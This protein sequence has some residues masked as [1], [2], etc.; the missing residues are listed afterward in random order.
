MK[1]KKYIPRL[2]AIAGFSLA[3]NPANAALLAHYTFDVDNS[4]STPDSVGSNSA[5]LGNRVEINTTI[6]GRIGSGALEMLGSGSTSGPGDGATTSN[7]F[8]W[9][10]DARTV[11]FWWRAD[12]PN[13]DVEGTFVSFGDESAN[14][15]RFDIKEQAA[16]STE[17]RVEVQG[18]GQNTN[19]GIDD[20]NWHFIAV[21]VPN[22]ATFADISW[23]VDGSST[24]LNTSTNT[25]AIATGTGAITFGDSILTAGG[26]DRVPNGF[27]D[28]FQ[29]YDE[30]L[31]QSQISFLFNNP[32][33]AVPE[34]SS[35]ALLGLG[36]LALI[37]R[38]RK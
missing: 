26:N 38:R 15:T 23:Y 35:T 16:S 24:D 22:D 1:S 14:G 27:L 9:T 13:V 6:T 31:D 7:S 4:G 33:T 12:S 17:L 3:A 19:P 28:D 25:L 32:G 10:N 37:L 34:P 18:T 36:G 8:S 11:T 2:L 29:L 20:G 30:V 21:T 5:T